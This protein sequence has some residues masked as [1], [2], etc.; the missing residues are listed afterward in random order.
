M[1]KLNKKKPLLNTEASNIIIIQAKN[2]AK[3]LTCF[4]IEDFK[5]EALFL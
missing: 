5:F 2:Y 3:E 1:I 4:V